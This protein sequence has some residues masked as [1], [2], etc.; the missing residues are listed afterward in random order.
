MFNTLLVFLLGLVAGAVVCILLS[1]AL[2]F[3]TDKSGP[4][5][6]GEGGLVG[7]G[8]AANERV[9]NERSASWTSRLENLTTTLESPT[10][11]AP[12]REGLYFAD[13]CCEFGFFVGLHSINIGFSI[14]RKVVSQSRCHIIT[15]VLCETKK[16][17][18]VCCISVHDM[19]YIGVCCFLYMCVY[20]HTHNMYIFIYWGA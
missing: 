16:K 19:K 8:T 13:K 4:Q 15:Y 5:G 12:L 11:L 18:C 3:P 6:L 2:L 10:V 14:G 20:D 9:R 7:R 17:A 1:I